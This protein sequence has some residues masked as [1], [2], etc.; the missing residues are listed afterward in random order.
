M[1]Y[2]ITPPGGSWDQSDAGSYSI[3]LAASQVADVAGNFVAANASLTSFSVS[4]N[5][6]PVN[7]GLP[8]GDRDCAGQWHAQWQPQAVGA[9]TKMI[10]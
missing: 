8:C 9:M 1:T 6:A 7:T 2:A 4:Y 5:A 3:N 10:P